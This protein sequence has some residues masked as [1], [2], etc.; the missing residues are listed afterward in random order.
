MNQKLVDLYPF[1]YYYYYYCYWT[2]ATI[3]CSSHDFAATTLFFFT[4]TC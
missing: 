1:Y 3:E 4:N 2:I